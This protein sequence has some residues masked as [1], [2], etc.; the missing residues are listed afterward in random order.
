MT[1]PM[2]RRQRSSPA[3]VHLTSDAFGEFTVRHQVAEQMRLLIR[4]QDLTSDH[5]RVI[6]VC[7]TV[8]GEGASY[9]TRALGAVVAYDTGRSVCVVDCDWTEEIGDENIGVAAYLGGQ[10]EAKALPVATNFENLFYVPAGAVP[11]TGRGP[12]ANSQALSQMVSD[13]SEEFEVVL[14]D[15]PPLASSAYA[16]SIAHLADESLLVVRQGAV[17]IERIE[18]A[19]G[20]LGDDHV[21]GVVLN[22]AKIRSPAWLVS[23]LIAG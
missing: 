22:D 13:L 4:R 9:I 15:V 20:D 3:D 17:P 16:V 2:R 23:P 12:A 1:G 18:L 14:L 6:S 7:A 8:R 5:H 10:V 11:I 19:M 21:S